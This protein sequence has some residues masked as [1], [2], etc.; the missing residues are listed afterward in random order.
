M[1]PAVPSEDD[2]GHELVRRARDEVAVEGEDLTGSRRG[3]QDEAGED[4]RPDSVQLILERRDDAEVAAAA[5]EAPEEV[6]V[7]PAMP[8]WLL[9]PRPR[10]RARVRIRRRPGHRRRRYS[11]R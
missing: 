6:G 7:R 4:G 5:A 1:A 2:D 8:V 3:V 9:A 11:A 10:A